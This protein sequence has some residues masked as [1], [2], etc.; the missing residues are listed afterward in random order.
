MLDVGWCVCKSLTMIPWQEFVDVQACARV[1]A[2]MC[3]SADVVIGWLL[4]VAIGCCWILLDA[5]GCCYT[6]VGH[7]THKDNGGP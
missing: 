1:G 6:Q 5:V 7:D 4:V 2:C 3:A